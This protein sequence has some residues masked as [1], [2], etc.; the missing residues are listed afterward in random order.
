MLSYFDHLKRTVVAHGLIDQPTRLYKLY[1]VDENGM[2]LDPKPLK[3]V[4][5]KG[6]NKVHGR[7]LL[8][9]RHR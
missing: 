8:A 6:A 2:S 5:F 9:T 3:N 4:A 7:E 1:N